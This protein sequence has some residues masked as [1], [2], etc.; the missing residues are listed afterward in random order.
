LFSGTG[1][2]AGLSPLPDKFSPRPAPTCQRCSV[3]PSLWPSPPTRTISADRGAG[4]AAMRA[5]ARL[6]NGFL[7]LVSAADSFTWLY[8]HTTTRRT[9]FFCPVE[10]F[11][12]P[13]SGSHPPTGST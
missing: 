4:Y 3:Q 13:F 11:T 1:T 8:S 12:P 9:K 7:A 2:L 10:P 5:G 6:P